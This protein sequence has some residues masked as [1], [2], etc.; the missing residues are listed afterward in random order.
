MAISDYLMNYPQAPKLKTNYAANALQNLQG[1]PFAGLAAAI[2]TPFAAKTDRENEQALQ[3]YAQEAGLAQ[4]LRDWNRED[5]VAQRNRGWALED[6]QTARE[7]KTAD[8]LERYARE[9]ALAERNRQWAQEDRNALWDRQDDVAQR[10]RGWTVADRL[11]N[12]NRED[13]LRANATADALEK[14][15]AEQ[16]QKQAA[17]DQSRQTALRGLSELQGIADRD[18]IGAFTRFRNSL[19]IIGD[20]TRQDLGKISGAVAAI[21]PMAIERLKAAGVSGV[22]SL[23]E[24]MTY[25]G[26]PEDPTSQEI[27][28]A[29]PLIRQT[30]GLD[31]TQGDK[32]KLDRY[33]KKYGL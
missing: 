1:N 20:D 14:Y 19:N 25:V 2:L 13:R 27:A 4:T 5:A 32:A 29:L 30:L 12:W 33:N 11:E 18:S 7:N 16:A 10:Q 23:P 22:N 3:Q 15:A 8:M 6:A 17:A 31:P 24:F 28:G 9:D 26:L 21:A